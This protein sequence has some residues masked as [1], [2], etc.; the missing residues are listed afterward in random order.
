MRTL[1]CLHGAMLMESQPLTEAGLAD[2]IRRAMGEFL[3][4]PG[5]Q[6]T[7]AQAARLWCLDS[8]LCSRVL[9][10]LV[11]ARFLV[12]TPKALFSRP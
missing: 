2:A 9:T 7:E 10:A 4:M 8:A 1:D 12:R 5:L 6:L 3:E 11:D